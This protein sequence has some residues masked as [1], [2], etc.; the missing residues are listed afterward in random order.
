MADG[1]SSRRRPLSRHRR[2]LGSG[3][4]SVLRAGLLP[5]L[6]AGV[7][8]VSGAGGRCCCGRASA[9]WKRSG[10]RWCRPRRIRSPT[11]STRSPRPPACCSP[12]ISSRSCSPP[13]RSD[14]ERDAFVD[15]LV[16]A[17]ADRTVEPSS[18]SRCAPTSTA[19]SPPIRRSPSCWARTTSS[20]GR[21]K[22]RSCAAPSS[23]RP[24]ASACRRAGAGRRARRRRGGR[25]GRAAVAFHRTARALAEAGGNTLTLAAYRDSGGVHG[26]VARLAEGTYAGP[27][28][29]SRSCARSCC[30]WS[31]RARARRSC[32]AGRR[33]PARH[34]TQRGGR[35]ACSRSLADSRLV[36]VS[37]GIV[38][39]AHEALLREWPRLREW[40]DEDAQGRR[41]RATSRRRPASGT[42]PAATRTSSTAAPA[43]PPPSTGAPSTRWSSTSS[44]AQF[45]AES[46]EA[47]EQETSRVRRTNRRLRAL[48]AGVA[49][50]LAAAVAGGSARWRSDGEA[51]DAETAQ[52]AQRLGAQ[53]LVEDDLD[54]SL[55][56]A[57]QAVEIDDSPQT[58][59]TLLAALLRAP[60]AIGIM[61]GS[62]PTTSSRRSPSAPTAA[63]RG[64]R[65]SAELL[66]FDARDVRADRRPACSFVWD[67]RLV[68]I[69]YSPDGRRSPFDGDRLRPP[70]RRPHRRAARGDVRAGSAA[71]MA[72]TS[73]G[74]RL[75]ALMTAGVPRRHGP[76]RG[77]A[78]A[79]G[80]AIEPEGFRPTS[81]SFA[82]YRTRAAARRSIAH[83]GVRHG[84]LGVVGPRDR[85][86]TRAPDR[87]RLSRARAQPRRAHRRGRL[88]GGLQLLDLRSGRRCD[89]R[90]RRGARTG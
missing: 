75:V 33:W 42:P 66:L 11:P 16:E 6:A 41:L 71:R 52:L 62:A 20:S 10:R 12:S 39:V 26:A 47:S 48:L 58:R 73:D 67:L 57:R 77:H 31:A 51:R 74:S 21:C 4:S 19:A 14:A 25:A 65:A 44:S 40:I 78:R 23:C 30:A 64:R 34:R 50:L 83:H 59:S 54:R 1:R 15:A 17:A 43:S 89:R 49:V 80:A 87:N 35:A 22:P 82:R 55:L 53:A 36:T 72:F 61:P 8:P 84:E 7:L 27:R 86:K 69:A 2:P 46:R 18:W 79:M 24:R 3:K 90:S 28:A 81:P 70:D 63:A 38:E 37:D 60:A 88:H 76:R 32:A 5:A 68:S 56:L 13:A 29:G 85:R 9:R 45:V